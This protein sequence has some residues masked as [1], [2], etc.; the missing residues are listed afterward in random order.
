MWFLYAE[1]FL[2]ITSSFLVGAV[3]GLVG[4]RLMLPTEADVRAKAATAGFL[5]EG[6]GEAR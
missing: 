3:V 1:I 2:L 4:I 6:A 5:P